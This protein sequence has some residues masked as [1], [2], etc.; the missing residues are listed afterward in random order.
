MHTEF[1]TVPLLL[2]SPL[3]LVPLAPLSQALTILAR[4]MVA[5]HPGLISRLGPYVS[6]SFAVDPTDLPVTLLLHPHPTSMRI[7]LHRDP[8]RADARIA[9]PLSALLGLVH[10]T[11][12]GDALFFSRDLVIDGDTSAALALRNAIDDCE[13]DLGAEIAGLTGPF[14]RLLMPFIALAERRTGMPLRRAEARP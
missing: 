11:W 3:R 9:G 2:A 4:R 6:S 14:G 1:P 13:I 5:N 10:G 7:T 8:P 12:D